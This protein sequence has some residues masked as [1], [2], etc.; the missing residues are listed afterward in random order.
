MAT[1]ARSLPPADSRHILAEVTR[2][3]ERIDSIDQNVRDI[4]QT[5]GEQAVVL[6]EH[7]QNLA[8]IKQTLAEHTVRL[9]AL[10]DKVDGGFARMDE[11]FERMDRKFAR[12]FQLMGAD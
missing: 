10:E 12:V 5:Q 7:S 11:N 9:N 6:A 8:I 1:V 4:R 2:H 3:Q